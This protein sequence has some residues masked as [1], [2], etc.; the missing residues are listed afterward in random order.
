MKV[1][2]L[3][4]AVLLT[5]A[6]YVSTL[7]ANGPKTIQMLDF[8]QFEPWMHRET[9]SVYVINFWATWCAPCIREIPDFEKINEV[10]A[11]A[12]VKVLLVSLDFPGQINSRVIPFLERMNVK[13]QVLLMD[14]VNSNRWIP[15]V[16]EEWTG[17]I[18]AT[19]VYS[20]NYR[21]FFEQELKYEELENII[22]PLLQ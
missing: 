21:G 15:L 12:G 11:P 16:S 8:D 19:L 2:P 4:I 5:G 3:Y 13:S 10:Y 17:A 14:D 22:K 18:P 1:K 6:M 7:T 9:D 20:K